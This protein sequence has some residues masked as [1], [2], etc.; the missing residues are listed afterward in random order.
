M[1]FPGDTAEVFLNA[2]LDNG[3]TFT[4]FLGNG[5]LF[6]S[7]VSAS[8]SI[9]DSTHWAG[10]SLCPLEQTCQQTALL[11]APVSSTS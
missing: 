10:F 9:E 1:G 11:L 6:F 7:S 5:C 8:S 2:L 4:Q 3:A